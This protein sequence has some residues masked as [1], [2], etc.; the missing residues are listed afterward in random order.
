LLQAWVFSAAFLVAYVYLVSADRFRGF[1]VWAAAAAACILCAVLGGAP[2]LLAL[3]RGIDIG[4]LMIFSGILLIAEVLVETK[5]PA[6]IAE[7]LVTV[8]GTLGRASLL[9]CILSGAI[10]MWVENV[11]TVML[12]APVALELARRLEANPVPLLIGIAISSNLQGT[13]T[14][15]GDP[16]SMILA[17]A[18]KL[19]FND[20]FFMD[21]RLGIF[22]AVQCG[23]VASAFVLWRIFRRNRRVVAWHGATQVTSWVPVVIFVLTILGLALA[24][25]SG[26]AGLPARLTPGLLSGII[27]VVGGLVALVWHT[28]SHRG[29]LPPFLRSRVTDEEGSV[30]NS[31]QIIKGFD[32]DTVLLLAGIF[33]MVGAL[34]TY[35]VI[36]WLGGLI[37]DLS[38]GGALSA[39]LIIVAASM[40]ISAFVD[41]VPFVTAMLPVVHSV[42]IDMGLADWRFLSFGMLIGACLGG[43][44]SPIGASANIVSISLLRK[45]GYTV[46][47][48]EFVSIGLPFTLVA[49]TF[50]A[51]FVWF[52]WGP[53]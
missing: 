12:L 35:G 3:L 7:K 31:W 14:L 10:S 2:N 4:I 43:N 41:N 40:V 33:F 37:A 32:L 24:S 42:A 47:F 48:R 38:G 28:L 34:D 46:S 1:A 36:D 9:L 8:S 45:A 22:F 13:A 44:I 51:A 29:V 49:V 21:G 25:F 17:A 39:Y 23:A 5:A 15:V 53:Y 27:C 11:A 16:P 18:E 19:T 26:S 20:F 6:W 30:R 52:V 50:G